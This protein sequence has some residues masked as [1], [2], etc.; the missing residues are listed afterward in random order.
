[1]FMGLLTPEVEIV[2]LGAISLQIVSA[3][4]IIYGLGM[5]LVNAFNGAGD[6]Q[7]PFRINIVAFW[8]VEIP[9]AW[10][11]STQTGWAQQGV[12]WSIIIAETMMTLTVL[13]F[14]Q[15]GNWKLKEV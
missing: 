9:L 5:V 10:F 3:G 1:M 8:M 7:T 14:F 6:T 4:L 13:Y 12:F 11:L 2:D 15:K